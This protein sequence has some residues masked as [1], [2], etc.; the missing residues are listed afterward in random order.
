MAVPGNAYCSSVTAFGRSGHA[1]GNH[2]RSQEV[3]PAH[4]PAAHLAAIA[5]EAGCGLVILHRDFA[6]FAEL[7]WRHPLMP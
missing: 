5:L 2:G 1:A 3:T 4:V 7:R 6:R